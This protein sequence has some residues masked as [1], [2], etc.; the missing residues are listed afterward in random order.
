MMHSPLNCG[1]RVGLLYSCL[2]E[3]GF[4]YFH[5]NKTAPV[6]DQNEGDDLHR[7]FISVHAEGPLPTEAAAAAAAGQGIVSIYSL[8]DRSKAVD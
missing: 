8:V 6:L 3:A 4:L 7:M 1:D 2:L 5:K